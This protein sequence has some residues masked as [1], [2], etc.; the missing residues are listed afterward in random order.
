MQQVEEA[1]RRYK[2]AH[3]ISPQFETL[4]LLMGT[5]YQENGRFS[6]A[7]KHFESELQRQPASDRFRFELA[8]T[9]LMMQEYDPAIEHLQIVVRKTPDDEFL[10]QYLV[11][12]LWELGRPEA[13]DRVIREW[14]ATHV[15]NTRLREFYNASQQGIVNFPSDV[16]ESGR[17]V[18]SVPVIPGSRGDS[19]TGTP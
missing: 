14:E 7:R 3:Q 2:T 6:E 15:G 17:R 13:T 11:F 18:P 4:S 5:V 19:M 10:W 12:T 16:P 9:L 1:I 8:R